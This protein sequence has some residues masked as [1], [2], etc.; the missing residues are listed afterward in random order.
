VIMNQACFVIYTRL[1]FS[2]FKERS[3]AGPA[4]VFFHGGGFTIN[5]LGLLCVHYV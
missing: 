3:E 5:N 2:G 1:R 4:I